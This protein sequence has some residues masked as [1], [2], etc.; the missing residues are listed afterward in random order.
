MSNYN[1]SEMAKPN[2]NVIRTTPE[3]TVKHPIRY[4]NDAA[5]F[6]NSNRRITKISMPKRRI[7]PEA[8]HFLDILPH[9][10]IL[11]HSK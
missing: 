7:M 6:V 9:S 5:R 10:H 8:I 2:S 4:I 11:T 3:K 1:P